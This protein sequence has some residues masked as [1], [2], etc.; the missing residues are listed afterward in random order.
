[1]GQR[2]IEIYPSG[3]FLSKWA[4]IDPLEGIYEQNG[5]KVITKIQNGTH[6]TYTCRVKNE[7]KKKV[8]WNANTP[9]ARISSFASDIF[10]APSENQQQRL[11]LNYEIFMILIRGVLII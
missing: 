7:S 9:I 4:K 3:N 2:K 11:A 1:M 6:D 5:V 8:K 10:C